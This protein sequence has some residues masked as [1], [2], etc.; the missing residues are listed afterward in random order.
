[1]AAVTVV[2]KKYNVSGQKKFRHYVLTGADTNTLD[3]GLNSVDNTLCEPGTITAVAK[4]TVSGR[5]RLTFS[6]SGP[7]T[8]L[9]V[10][11]IGN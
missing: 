6:A 10:L 1:M 2:S 11:V 5:I 9:P 8:A 3:T 7:F 4:S